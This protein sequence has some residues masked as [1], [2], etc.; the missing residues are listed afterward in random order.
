MTI[1]ELLK[2]KSEGFRLTDYYRWLVWN[3]SDQWEV[4]EQPYGKRAW[5][6]YCGESLEKA[7]EILRERR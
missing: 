5:S 3:L 2:D 7:L 6:I 1:E 4:F